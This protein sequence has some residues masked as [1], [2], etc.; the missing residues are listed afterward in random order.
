[1]LLWAS[2]A[3]ATITIGQVQPAAA[4]PDTCGPS[5]GSVI[6]PTVTSGTPYVV[7]VN[8][9]RIT[10]WSTRA[11]S[12]SNQTLALRV[13]RPLGGAVYMAVGH[14]GPRALIPSTVNTF[15]VNI[16]VRPGDVVGADSSNT[17]NFPVACMF[18]VPGETY[19]TSFPSP[20]PDEGT[21]ATFHSGPNQRV[22]LSAEVEVSN[23]FS[24]VSLSR[25]KKKGRATATVDVP[26]AGNVSVGGKGLAAQSRHSDGGPVALG[27]IPNKKTHR[28]LLAKGRARVTASFTYAPTGGTPNTQSE[29]VKLILR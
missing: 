15:P 6:Q 19:W 13:L 24:F 17:P 3:A 28:K 18:T 21:S 8:G 16:P 14:D 12:T 7:P 10:S 26:G 11:N 23:V 2:P 4:T 5:S 1:M 22:N 27:V 20:N 29:K 9:I 25:N